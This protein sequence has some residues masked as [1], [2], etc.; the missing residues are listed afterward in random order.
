MHLTLP[1]TEMLDI[2]LRGKPLPAMVRDVGCTGSTVHASL[3]LRE[4]AAAA[5]PVTAPK[6]LAMVARAVPVVRLGGTLVGFSQGRVTADLTVQAGPVPVHRVLGLLTGI[7][8]SAL[9]ARGLPTGLL[10]VERGPGGEP[11]L[12]VDVQ[13]VLDKRVP[14]LVLTGVA[15]VDGVLQVEAAARKVL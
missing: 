15:M 1:F 4:L 10:D 3:D 6:A 12:V 11:R 5:V 8:N 14:G 2:A 13:R 7:A 9:R